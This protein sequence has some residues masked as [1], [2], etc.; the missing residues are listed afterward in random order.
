[1]HDKQ[2]ALV[3]KQIQKQKEEDLDYKIAF[4]NFVRTHAATHRFQYV[5]RMSGTTTTTPFLTASTTNKIP[6]GNLVPYYPNHQT[7]ITNLSTEGGENAKYNENTDLID[8]GKPNHLPTFT[9]LTNIP[10]INVTTPLHY[11]YQNSQDNSP[12][13]QGQRNKTANNSSQDLKARVRVMQFAPIPRVKPTK[14]SAME[15]DR[16]PK[17]LAVTPSHRLLDTTNDLTRKF[18]QKTPIKPPLQTK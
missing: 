8:W 2:V 5:E 3:L 7:T 9:A 1:M 13:R 6:P 11:E 15:I 18:P 14:M 16:P 12:L 4:N 17:S 10:L